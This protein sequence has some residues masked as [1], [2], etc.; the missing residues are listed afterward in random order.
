MI[1]CKTT[2]RVAVDLYRMSCLLLTI[3]TI[4]NIATVLDT[5]RTH[6]MSNVEKL[7]S[8]L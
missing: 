6:N 1:K 4:T 3:I 7:V 8:K 5:N 2:I